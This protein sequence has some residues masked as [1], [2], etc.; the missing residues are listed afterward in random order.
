M[1]PSLPMTVARCRIGLVTFLAVAC[2][3]ITTPALAQTS[4]APT[5]FRIFL[6]DGSTVVSYGEY[7]RVDDEVVFSMPLGA[8]AREPRL[9]LITLP[10]SLVNWPR[11]E[12][13]ALS[14]RYQRYATTRGE[15]DFAALT[16]EVAAM[17]NQIALTTEKSRALEIASEAR[18]LLVEW[19][20]THF[21][22]R[23]ND[24]TDIVAL[25]DEAIS[26]LGPADGGG[27]VQ[28]SL[29][30]LSPP[31]DVEPV[32]G[33]M[34]PRD[35][36]ARQYVRAPVDGKVMALRVS[37][38]GEVIGPRDP[39]LD[40]V[41]TQEKLVVEANVRPQDI[42]HV[43]E[44]SAAEVRLSSFDARTTPLLPGRVV[45]VSADR[46]TAPETGQSWFVATV[47]VDASALAAHPQIRL[48]AG[49]PAELFV[50]TP[51]RTLFEYLARPFTVFATRALR[52][53]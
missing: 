8:P 1:L 46:V 10:A 40:I 31:I 5:L 45:F 25:I 33:M 50:K 41:P 27:A 37:A 49:M 53:P 38:V 13:Y 22:Y 51:E 44:S 36:V 30:A 19:P 34:T 23:Q 15:S 11:T 17:L 29:V 16:A 32:L 18:R 21:G 43:R 52:E 2:V 3:E 28:L 47:E 6:N 9:Q 7:A 4:A 12:R 26:G 20:A 39:L 48:Q 24:I 42:N 35:Q 14:A